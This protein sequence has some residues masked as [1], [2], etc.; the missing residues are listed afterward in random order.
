M[1]IPL[2]HCAQAATLTVNFQEQLQN[3]LDAMEERHVKQSE[4]VIQQGDDG[5]NFYIIERLFLAKIILTLGRQKSVNFVFFITCGL[6]EK[7]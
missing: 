4:V 7:N 3:I 6:H 2:W 1:E 5:D